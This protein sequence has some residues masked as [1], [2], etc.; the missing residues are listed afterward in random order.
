MHTRK[1]IL[2][3]CVFLV[4]AMP[5]IASADEVTRQLW[6]DYHHHTYVNLHWELQGEAGCRLSSD[7]TP[8]TKIYARPTMRWH[9][10]GKPIE[11]RFGVGAFYTFGESSSDVFE[12]RPSGGAL[13][14][15]PTVGR[16]TLVSQVRIEDRLQWTTT[17]WNFE[18]I[19]RIRYMLATKVPLSR[20][21]GES[22]FF[23]PISAEA[24]EDIGSGVRVQSSEQFRFDTGVGLVFDRE[25]V[26]EVHLIAQ[27]SKSSS[28]G[29]FETTDLIVRVELLR[30]AAQDYMKTH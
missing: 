20:D 30:L 17:D 15:W 6:L 5:A 8:G 27:K 3:T 21:L 7:S 13:L 18:D 2:I 19:W 16:L 29:T 14:K 26:A 1:L 24:F 22:Y 25:W 28:T 11:L 12:V 9:P 23:V 4:G 10:L